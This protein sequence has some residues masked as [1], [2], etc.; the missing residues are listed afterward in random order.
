M[1][2]SKKSRLSPEARSKLGKDW[3]IYVPGVVVEVKVKVK[4]GNI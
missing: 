4:V 2:V 1:F 3:I